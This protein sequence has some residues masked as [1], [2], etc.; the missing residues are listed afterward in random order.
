LT[1]RTSFLLHDGPDFDT[2]ALLLG[3][4]TGI[5]GLILLFLLSGW[6]APL[7]LIAFLCFSASTGLEIDPEGLKSR[8]VTSFLLFQ[9]PGEW[10][11]LARPDAVIL[12]TETEYSKASMGLVF[13]ANFS[14]KNYF[15]VLEFG[16]RQQLFFEFSSYERACESG[17]KL[18]E[19]F[20]C[21]FR[22]RIL[23][24]L[25]QNQTSRRR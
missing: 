3:I 1:K 15:L 11:P 8:K 25:A 22:D 2:G 7:L 24:S 6:S 17:E 5:S 21:P 23:E 10:N 20:G 18:A 19:T 9:L 14:R 13:N 12:L 16:P 4:L